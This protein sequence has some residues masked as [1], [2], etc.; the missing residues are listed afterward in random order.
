MPRRNPHGSAN[1]PSGGKGK[2]ENLPFPRLTITRPGFEATWV[3]EKAGWHIEILDKKRTVIFPEEL[4]EFRIL[5]TRMI[6][7]GP[8]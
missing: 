4:E 8:S 7:D 5:I 3:P 2:Q 1:K 6:E